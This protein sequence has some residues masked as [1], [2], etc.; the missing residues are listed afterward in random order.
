MENCEI[1]HETIIRDIVDTVSDFKN[2]DAFQGIFSRQSIKSI[3]RASAN[4]TLV[5]PVMVTKDTNIENASMVC[6][7]I[8]RKAVSMLQ[9]LFSAINIS[10]APNAMEY[11]KNFHTNIDFGDTLSVDEFIGAIDSYAATHEDTVFITDK[12]AYTLIKEDM[13]R[14]DFHLKIEPSAYSINDYMVRRNPYTGTLEANLIREADCKDFVDREIKY[15]Q[16]RKAAG[17]T[18]KGQVLDSDIK[19]ANE[20]V[21]SMMIINFVSPFNGETV[22]TNAVIGVKAKMY[23]IDQQDAIDRIVLKNKDK[24]GLLSVIK[25]STREISFWKD[26]VFAIDRAKLDALSSAGR[27]SS[28]RIWKL[29]ERR[30]IKSRIKRSLGALNDASAITSL[31]ITQN[32]VDQLKKEE[33]IDITKP[34]TLAGIMD[35]YNLMA[36]VIIDEVME[37]VKFLYDDGAEAF[38]TLSFTHLERE[39]ADNGY[40]KIINLMTKVAR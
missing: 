13:K 15:T 6:K 18:F 27:G 31:V 21:P 3:A 38:E 39:T 2:S 22:S 8:E 40:K 1:I 32:V 12:D 17:D 11:I 26:L 10:D 16:Q 20:L 33:N 25:A 30:G 28:S 4:L 24:N 23:V 5:F 36:F 29:L 34:S 37:T 35:A 7:A 19:K 14:L 9:M